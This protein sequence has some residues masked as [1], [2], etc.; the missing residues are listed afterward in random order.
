MQMPFKNFSIFSSGGHFVW[1][2]G[3][4]WA[5][6]VVGLMRNHSVKLL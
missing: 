2:S 6:L 4:V 3:T 1:W 5:T